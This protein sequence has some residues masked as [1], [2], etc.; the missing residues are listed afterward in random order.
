MPEKNVYLLFVR[1][2]VLYIIHS[3][4]ILYIF[5]YNFYLLKPLVFEKGVWSLH[6]Q[7]LIY[8]CFMRIY[9]FEF[10]W[11]YLLAVWFFLPVTYDSFQLEFYFVKCWYCYPSF[12]IW[13]HL[14]P[15][16]IFISLK[17]S[18]WKWNGGY[19]RLGREGDC[20]DEE[21]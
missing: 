20:R 15:P 14:F 8:P 17:K 11:L 9:G 18:F 10:R 21:K 19:Q 4:S 5:A 6:P 2:W 13:A 16:F 1:R 3:S 12:P 7:L